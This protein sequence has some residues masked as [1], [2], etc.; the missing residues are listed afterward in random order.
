MTNINIDPHYFENTEASHVRPIQGECGETD[1][2]SDPLLLAVKWD[3]MTEF[4][5]SSYS[6]FIYNTSI[7]VQP[8]E[9]RKSEQD[10]AIIQKFID[11]FKSNDNPDIKGILAC[12]P[13]KYPIEKLTGQFI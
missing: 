4:I 1:S 10:E 7:E 12:N 13:N 8:Y 6:I 3:N 2:L 5:Y 11:F 9:E